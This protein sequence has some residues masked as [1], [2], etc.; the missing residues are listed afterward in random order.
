[1]PEPPITALTGTFSGASLM[2]SSPA[3]GARRANAGERVAAGVL[4]LGALALL[5]TAAVLKPSPTGSGTHTQL[6][7]PSCTWLTTFGVP[8]PTCGMTTSFSYAAEG[9]YVDS[10]LAQPAGFVLVLL[11]SMTVWI[12]G[13]IAVLGSTIGRSMTRLMGSWLA[14]V[15][16]SLLI[17]AWLYKIA[18]HQH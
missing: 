16:L 4:A 7:L 1:M 11:T 12:G 9:S 6:G 17:G 5:V 15:G 14:W 8:C 2:K 3:S 13:H 18:T 10:V